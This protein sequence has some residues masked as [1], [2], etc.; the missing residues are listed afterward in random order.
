MSFYSILLQHPTHDIC[1]REIRAL[2]VEKVDFLI[3]SGDR[4]EEHFL[5]RLLV[6]GG[7]TLRATVPVES[8]TIQLHQLVITTTKRNV[9]VKRKCIKRITAKASNTLYTTSTLRRGMF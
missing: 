3:F 5:C 9:I 4:L 2:T 6:P 7:V 1:Q 8:Q